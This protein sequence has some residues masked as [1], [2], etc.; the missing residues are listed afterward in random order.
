MCVM[1]RAIVVSGQAKEVAAAAVGQDFSMG[2]IFCV[3][4]RQC[5]M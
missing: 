4:D 3:D 2:L 1:R 5:G